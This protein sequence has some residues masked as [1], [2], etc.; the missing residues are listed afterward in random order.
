MSTHVYNNPET[1][2]KNNALQ[3]N[4]AMGILKTIE[5][6]PCSRILDIGCGDGKIT[7]ELAELA[8]EGCVIGTDVSFFMV[9]HAAKTYQ[10][11]QNLGFMQMD[12]SK[13]KFINQF[14]LITSFNCLHWIK[15]QEKTLYGIAR[16]A[17]K[18]AKIVLLLSHKKSIYH[19]ALDGICGNSKWLP[20]FKNYVNP[21][22][23]F[24]VD[25]YKNIL[26]QAGLKDI[27]ISEEEL[28]Y[29][30]DS[31]ESLIAFFDSSMANVKQVP[32]EKKE[33]FLDDYC[34]EFLKQLNLKN[35]NHFPVV[36]WSLI[37][38]AERG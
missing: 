15:D 2:S 23:F 22:S 27:E 32:I 1:Y 24:D 11:Q 36:F 3:Y 13:N 18:N 34:N 37:V 9:E 8:N 38:K 31:R 14:D 5:I 25:A 4:F 6:D 19:Y 7:F 12:G 33:E 29:N 20:Y 21:R 35:T 16:A 28:T 26:V 17:V 30:F 10:A